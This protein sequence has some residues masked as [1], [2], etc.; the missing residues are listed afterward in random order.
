[1]VQKI[2]WHPSGDG[3]TIDLYSLPETQN[4]PSEQAGDWLE[5]NV[6]TAWP[7]GRNVEP[8][9]SVFICQNR[10]PGRRKDPALP[11]SKFP[12]SGHDDTFHSVH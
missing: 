9:L 8:V 4:Q 11:V 3:H 12:S 7:Q 2:E 10:N 6:W 5:R 1:M